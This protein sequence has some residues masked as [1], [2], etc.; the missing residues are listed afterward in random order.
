M[1][2]VAGKQVRMLFHGIMTRG[3]DRTVTWNG[4]DESGNRVP[5]GVDFDQLVTDGLVA[6]KKMVMLK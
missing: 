5:S 6:T 1:L 4:L 2:D 3:N